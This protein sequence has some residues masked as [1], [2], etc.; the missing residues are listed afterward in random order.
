M[1]SIF[2]I[3]KVSIGPSSSHTMGPMIADAPG[4]C[5]PI[6]NTIRDNWGNC[7]DGNA[8]KG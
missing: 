4:T 6:C 7:V 1:Y 5:L 8:I 2:D 3:F